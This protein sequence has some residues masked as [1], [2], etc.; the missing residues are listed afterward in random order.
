MADTID[1]QNSQ[2]KKMAA[3]AALVAAAGAVALSSEAHAAETEAQMTNVASLNNVVSTRRLEDGT[4]EVVLENGEVVRLGADSFVEKAGQFL[5]TPDALAEFTDGNGILLIGLGAA[6]IA[7][8]AIA[9][10]GDG[11]DA[12]APIVVDPNLPTAGNDVIQGTPNA[13]TIN[14]LAGDDTISG[15]AS[16]RRG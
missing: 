11:D 5:L 15:Y 13:D 6:A 9:A 14:G 3:K 2:K 1:K 7:A 16:R 10:S 12:P 4:L 8:I